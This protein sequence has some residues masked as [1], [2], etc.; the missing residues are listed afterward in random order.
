MGEKSTDGGRLHMFDGGT[1]KIAFY[2]DGTDNHI[3][4]NAGNINI[5]VA[6]GDDVKIMAGGENVIWGH[7]NG[8]VNLYYDSNLKLQTTANGVDIF[9]TASKFQGSGE[10]AVYIGSTDAGGASIYFDGDS[11]GDWIGSDYSWIRHTTGGDMEICADNPSNDGHIYLKV[12]SGNENSIICQ[13]NSSVELYFDT[14]KKFETTS[15]G[16]ELTGRLAIGSTSQLVNESAITATS[17]GNTA[18]FRATG[19]AAHS[20]LMCW[21]NHTSS[22]RTQIEF[23]DGSSY[24]SRGKITTDGSNVTY[25][26]TSDYRLKQDDV[27]I[28]DGITKVKALKPKRFKWKDNLSIGICDGFFAHEVQ[29]AAPTSGATIGTKDEVDDDGKPVYQSIDQSKLIPLLTA[30]IQ[31]LSAEIN[32][33]KTKVTALEAA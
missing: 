3:Y 30:A 19:A 20:P 14:S 26:G 2:T 9:G 12:A 31:E 25:G 33:L 1:E 24:T 10:V 7:G 6:A 5:D 21:N 8:E 18:C 28:T 32:T 4:T 11:N 17:G 27:L 15:T 29:E 23:A 22:D 16:G 13:A